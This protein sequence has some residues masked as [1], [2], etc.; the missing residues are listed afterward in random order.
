M[1]RLSALILFLS[2]ICITA[3]ANAEV[4]Y[5]NGVVTITDAPVNATAIAVAYKDDTLEKVKIQKVAENNQIDISSFLDIADTFKV[6][7]W[8]INTI[9]P[10]CD[11]TD[12]TDDM[13][14]DSSKSDNSMVLNIDR[15]SVV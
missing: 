8:D 5:K 3:C 14:N 1:K 4:L 13:E 2:V 6:F 7:L 9:A 15:K 12:L 11:A 10:L